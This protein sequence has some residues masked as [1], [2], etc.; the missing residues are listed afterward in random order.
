MRPADALV[1]DCPSG[2]HAGGLAD[3]E[4]NDGQEADPGPMQHA[5]RPIRS[6]AI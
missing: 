3:A 5:S 2:G 1:S 6:P 4:A